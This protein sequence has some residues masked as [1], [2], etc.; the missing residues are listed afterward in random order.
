MP[1]KIT[2]FQKKIFDWWEE[3]RRNFPWRETENPYHI[4]VSEIMLQ[5]TQA[6]RVVQK[7]LQF[8][9]KYPTLESLASAN[10][11]DLLGIWSGLGY[12]R[13]ALWLKEAATEIL[14]RKIFPKKIEDLEKLKGIGKYSARS[15]L[16]FAYNENLATVDTN[17][18]RI[19]ISEGF[20]T[21]ENSEKE[22]MS[23]AEMILPK[24]KSRDWHNALM[25]YGSIVLTV[26]KT[27]IKPT[28]KQG[29]FKGSDREIRGKILKTLLEKTNLS[30]EDL[31]KLFNITD[32]KITEITD[33]MVDDGLISKR[34]DIFF[35]K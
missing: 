4:L 12:N 22:L 24:G 8:L 23:I 3:N 19:L 13:R 6:P 27:G 32:K 30:K 21:E 15:I 33:K 28:S 10:Q 20:A 7:Y 14:D 5:Q 26:S 16:I 2:S 31:V 11:K 17:I 9:E 18:R 25:D 1:N 34:K 35:I 29:K